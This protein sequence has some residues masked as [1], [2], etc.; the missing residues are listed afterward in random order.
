MNIIRNLIGA[1]INKKYHSQTKDKAEKV[2]A[3]RVTV[4]RIENT[5]EIY[6]E[7]VRELKNCLTELI[8]KLGYKRVVFET[9]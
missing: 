8:G 2:N 3:Q 5:D 4:K 6:D 1:S 7:A 9:I